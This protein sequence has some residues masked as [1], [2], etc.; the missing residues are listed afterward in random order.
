MDLFGHTEN[1]QQIQ[2]KQTICISQ[3]ICASVQVVYNVCADINDTNI[4]HLVMVVLPNH[5]FF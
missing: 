4:D 2:R 5:S 1:R 3:K